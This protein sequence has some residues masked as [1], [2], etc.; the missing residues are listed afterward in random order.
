MYVAATN[1]VVSAVVVVEREEKGVLV[2]RPVYYLSKVLSAS[3]QNYPHYQKMAYDVYMAAKKPKH[4]FQ[5][6]PMKV[7]CEAPV[8]EIMSNKDASGRVVKWAVELSPYAPQ[9][10]RRGAIKSQ[11]LADFF[12]DWAEMQYSPPRPDPNFWSMHFDGSKMKDGL[13]ADIVLTLPTSSSL[14]RRRI[15]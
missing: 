14:R 15:N 10:E 9:Y 4:Y 3:K 13:G 6:H 12:V 8:S 1:R 2:Q 7:V 11:A 5:E